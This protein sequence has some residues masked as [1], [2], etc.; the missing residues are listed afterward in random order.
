M[1]ALSA[2]PC[3]GSRDEQ[4]HHCHPPSAYSLLRRND[5]E[6]NE[7]HKRHSETCAMR[8]FQQRALEVQDGYLYALQCATFLWAHSSITMG[9][10]GTSWQPIL[11]LP[12]TNYFLGRKKKFAVFS[13]TAYKA[14]TCWLENVKQSSC[15]CSGNEELWSIFWDTAFWGNKSIPHLIKLLYVLNEKYLYVVC[16]CV[17]A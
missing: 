8:R 16:V 6:A 11:I 15:P 9:E 5:R 10:G 2:R 17:K 1:L 14:T 4:D 12:I 7:Y 3:V 13:P